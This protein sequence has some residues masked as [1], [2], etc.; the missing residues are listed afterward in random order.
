MAIRPGMRQIR[1]LLLEGHD[2]ALKQCERLL[3]ILTHL[4]CEGKASFSK[5]LRGAREV[6]NFLKHDM[7]HHMAFEEKVIFPFLER[8]V[9]ALQP[10]VMLLWAEHKDLQKSTKRFEVL[11]SRLPRLADTR[12]RAREIHRLRDLGLYMIYLLRNH[13]EIESHCV[14][15]RVDRLLHVREKSLLRDQIKN[16]RLKQVA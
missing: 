4:Q 16:Y 15:A 5:N 14:Y 3:E 10:A 7:A 11:V 6:L 12:A 9:P 13:T 2:E 1:R 8:H